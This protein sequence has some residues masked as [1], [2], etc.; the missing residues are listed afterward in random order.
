MDSNDVP[1]GDLGT[2]EMMRILDSPSMASGGHRW[3]L[4]V[5]S[6]IFSPVEMG[7]VLNAKQT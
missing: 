4:E 7:V 6:D 5:E 2:N 3:T 1:I